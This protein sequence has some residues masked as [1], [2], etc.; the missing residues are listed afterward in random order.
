MADSNG[1]PM[2][3]RQPGLIESVQVMLRAMAEYFSVRF[4]MAGLESK[5]VIGKLVKAAIG[6]VVALLCLCAGLLYLS[7]S[8]I[9]VLAVKAHWGWG[10]ALLVSGVAALVVMTIG[11]LLARKALQGS[12]FPVTL[13]ELKKDSEWLKHKSQP[14]V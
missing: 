11:L 13:S 3:L 12:W 7:L 8:L 5:S 9:Y 10:C 14:T 4:E 1:T 2:G 6:F